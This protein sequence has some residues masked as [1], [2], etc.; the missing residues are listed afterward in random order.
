MTL[1]Q[2]REKSS[3]SSWIHSSAL[4]VA[5]QAT[6]SLYAEPQAKL[7]KNRRFVSSFDKE[8]K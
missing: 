3:Q 1:Q 7:Y 6:A 5:K 2:L 4:R 8:V